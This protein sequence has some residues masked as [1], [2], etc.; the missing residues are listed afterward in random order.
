VASQG[1]RRRPAAIAILEPHEKHEWRS[2]HAVNGLYHSD[3]ASVQ[4]HHYVLQNGL[5]LQAVQVTLYKMEN[6]GPFMRDPAP[7]MHRH[8]TT[9]FACR[10][11]LWVVKLSL[12]SLN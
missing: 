3:K 2:G 7:K 8:T 4:R 1:V 5:I 12:G 11:I 9:A 10:H 6:S